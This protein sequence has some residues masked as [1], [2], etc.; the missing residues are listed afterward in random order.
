[1]TMQNILIQIH[2]I[3]QKQTSMHEKFVNYVERPD[4]MTTQEQTSKHERFAKT[5]M[6]RYNDYSSNLSLP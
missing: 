4:K 2:L 6:T 3:I 5:R 1:M